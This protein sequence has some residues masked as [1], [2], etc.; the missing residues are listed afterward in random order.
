MAYDTAHDVAPPGSDGLRLGFLMYPQAEHAQGR[1][2][3]LDPNRFKYTISAR[4][5]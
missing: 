5:I 1:Y 4:E 2:D 3:P